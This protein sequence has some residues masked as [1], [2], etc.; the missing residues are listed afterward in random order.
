MLGAPTMLLRPI[1]LV[2]ALA[3]AVELDWI[4][5]FSV[6]DK[7]FTAAGDVVFSWTGTGTHNVEKMASFDAWESCDFSGA[8]LVGES[9]GAT[10]SGDDGETAYYACSVSSHCDWGQ[11]VAVTFEAPPGV[12]SAAPTSAAPSGA[13]TTAVR[14]ARRRRRR[15]QRARAP[16]RRRRRC[17]L[18]PRQRAASAAPGAPSSLPSVAPTAGPTPA[19]GADVD[20]LR[21]VGRAL[22]AVR[23]PA[24]RCA[25]GRAEEPGADGRRAAGADG[26]RAVGRAGAEPTAATTRRATA[27]PRA[28]RFTSRRRADVRRPPPR[29]LRAAWR[30][31]RAAVARAV[32]RV[33]AD[34][35][36]TTFYRPSPGPT[37]Y[38][39]SGAPTAP[40]TAATWHKANSPWKDCA[41]VAAYPPRCDALGEDGTLAYASC[42]VEA[43]GGT[44]P[45]SQAPTKTYVPPTAAPSAAP[46]VLDW[47]AQFSVSDK[48]TAVDAHRRLVFA[49]TGDHNVEQM[50]SRDHWEACDF[51]GARLVS[52]ASGAVA[53]GAAG[54]TSFYACSVGKHC[55]FGQK[56]AVDWTQPVPAPTACADRDDWYK[57]AQP[58]K[59]CPWVAA[60]LPSR[61]EAKGDDDTY[62]WEACRV[63]CGCTAPPSRAP[64]PACSPGGPAPTPRPARVFAPGAKTPEPSLWPTYGA[65]EVDS[66]DAKVTYRGNVNKKAAPRAEV[67]GA[68]LGS[69]FGVCVLLLVAVR[70]LGLHARRRNFVDRE[71]PPPKRDSDPATPAKAVACAVGTST[72]PA[73]RKAAALQSLNDWRDDGSG[74]LCLPPPPEAAPLTPD[75]DVCQLD[76]T[77]ADDDDAV[78]EDVLG[79]FD[80]SSPASS[81]R[82]PVAQARA[83]ARGDAAPGLAHLPDDLPKFDASEPLRAPDSPFDDDGPTESIRG[84]MTA[85]ERHIAASSPKNKNLA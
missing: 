51:A 59:D 14:A 43:C 68:Y 13:P 74:S 28:R 42:G 85:F 48:T 29:A 31:P 36:P 55:T 26:V 70:L 78:D 30:R 83:D 54:S 35:A 5:Q 38:R 49:W 76:M 80:Q 46:V 6:E 2:A 45:P 23:A 57:K 84:S 47:V 8:T 65:V 75:D 41:W 37:V 81:P 19:Y 1:I 56:V 61:C 73:D 62:A 17:R 15:R 72:S 64:T 27:E 44:T 4:A 52:N 25:R 7:T 58:W 3:R 69:F 22:R 20:D 16:G 67:E 18:S 40:P 60:L 12:P 39:P 11:K 50:A 9:S 10:A 82:N 33:P 21:A 34:R 79:G 71:A 24:A 66:V 53:V 63:T 32:A 77:I